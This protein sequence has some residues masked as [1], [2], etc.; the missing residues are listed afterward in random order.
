MWKWWWNILT[1]D[2]FRLPIAFIEPIQDSCSLVNGPVS[3]GVS[4]DKSN[5][6]AGAIHPNFQ[7]QIWSIYDLSKKEL[8]VVL[9]IHSAVTKKND[10]RC[11]NNFGT[12]NFIDSETK[13]K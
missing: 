9:T 4:S 13:A 10:V 12:C 5:G 8:S 1:L 3:S 11:N 2:D 7:E 6:V